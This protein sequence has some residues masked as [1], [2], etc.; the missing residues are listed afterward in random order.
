MPASE[1]YQHIMLENKDFHR[2]KFVGEKLDGKTAGIIG[3]SKIGSVVAKKLLG[4]G[5]NVVGYDPYISDERVA[6]LGITVQK[7]LMTF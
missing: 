2:N 5:M 4:A 6:R 3:L 7:I 1:I